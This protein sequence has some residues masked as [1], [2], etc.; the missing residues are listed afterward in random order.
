MFELVYYDD[1]V[2]YVSHYAKENILSTID[3]NRLR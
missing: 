1:V 2:Q 3:V